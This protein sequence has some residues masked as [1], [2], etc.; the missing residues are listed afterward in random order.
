MEPEETAVVPYGYEFEEGPPE[1]QFGEEELASRM[2]SVEGEFWEVPP[3]E[4]TWVPPEP[5]IRPP[6]A[7]ERAAAELKLG[8][9]KAKTEAELEAVKRKQEAAE[10]E[11][12]KKKRAETW[13]EKQRRYEKS[14]LAH[15]R[16]ERIRKEVGTYAGGIYKAVAAPGGKRELLRHREMYV[17][18]A[19]PGT[20]V[21]TGMQRLTTV[22]PAEAKAPSKI[23]EP[24]REVSAPRLGTLQRAGAPGTGLRTPIARAAMPSRSLTHPSMDLGHLKVRGDTVSLGMLREA[25]MPKGLSMI[26]KAAYAEIMGNGDRDTVKH[27]SSELAALGF[28]RKDTRT[29]IGSL[30]RKGLIKPTYEARGEEPVMEVVR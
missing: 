1:N 28:S 13:E 6:T 21:P 14:R 23:G 26:E 7:E 15:A 10:F 22:S 4:E 20:Y 2:R 29:A 3:G 19:T 27:I 16:R 30:A 18:K 11:L 12:E 17:P 25:S 8:L 5:A 24:L 9:E